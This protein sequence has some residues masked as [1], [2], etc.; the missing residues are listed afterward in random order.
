MVK[1]IDHVE[2][3]RKVLSANNDSHIN[4]EALY[5]DYDLSY[6][7]GRTEL[8]NIVQPVLAELR[9]GLNNIKSRMPPRFN[10]HSVELIGGGSRMP[11]IKTIIKDIFGMEPS[12][13]LNL[14]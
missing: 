6:S 11:Y 12:R 5:E 14:S 1:I 13:T 2:K 10:V 3:Q 4:V 9:K 8:E 7:M